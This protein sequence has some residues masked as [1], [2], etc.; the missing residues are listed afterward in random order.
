MLVFSGMILDKLGVR[1]TGIL[2]IAIMLIGGFIKYLAIS[3]HFHGMYELTIGSWQVIS[4]TTKSAVVAGFGFAIF[5][6]GCEMFGIAAN[7]AVVRWFRGKEMALAIG[8]N[9]STGRIG[10]ALAMFTPIPLIKLTGDISMP[11]IVSLF[12]LG[13]GML[14]FVLFTFMDRQLDQEDADAGIVEEE[15]FKFADIIEI[16]RNR[17]FWYITILCVLF[18]SAVFPF[19]KYATNMIVQKFGITDSFAGYIPALLPFSALLLTPVFG[20]MFDKKGRG[21][22]IM[23]IGSILLVCVHLLFSIPSLNSFP[24]AIGLVMLLGI[25]FSMV[26]SAMWPSIAKIIPEHKLGTAYAMTFWVQNWG[27]MGVPLLIGIVLDKYCITGTITKLVDGKEQVLTQYN[28]TI[29]MLIFACFGMI[30][31]VFSFLLKTEDRKKGY[32]LELPNI[33]HRK[34]TV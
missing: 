33:K 5:G 34:T 17:A 15:E 32:G 14:V 12:L 1:F 4:P 24:I 9:T 7:K 21:A 31:I 26:P 13:I 19:I 20:S 16:G 25:A 27:L 23:I 29:P 2:A 30:A 18:Y 3:G 8:L 22:T 6:V 28:Y 10:T 11:V